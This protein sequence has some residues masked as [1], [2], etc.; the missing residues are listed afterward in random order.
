MGKGSSKDSDSPKA[1]VG[2][3]INDSEQ[4]FT[5]Q[6]LSGKKTVETR[7]TNSLAPYVGKR[8]GIVRTGKGKAM[9]VGYATVGRP[10][11][12]KNKEEFDA[13]FK[14]HRVAPDSP[15][16]IGS[17]GKYGYPLT[18]VEKTEPVPVNKKGIIARSI[19]DLDG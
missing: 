4:D 9:L 3:N 12:Y 11:F 2:I 8:V 18:R 6:I 5:G 17:S 13:D 14:K 1:S 7:A 19:T 10:V 16:Y 15:H